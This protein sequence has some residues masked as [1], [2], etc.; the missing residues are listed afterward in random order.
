MRCLRDL[1]LNE[2]YRS[3]RNDLVSE[4]YVPC[5]ELAESY[6]SRRWDPRAQGLELRVTASKRSSTARQ[7][8]VWWRA[9][10]SRR[11]T[12]MPSKVDFALGTRL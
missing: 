8:R 1:G 6:D 11:R 7:P 9:P 12:S 10:S 2:E 5:L 3:D 4:F